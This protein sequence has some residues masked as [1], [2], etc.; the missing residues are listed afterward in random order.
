MK[1]LLAEYTAANDPALAPEGVAMLS[2][3][4]RSFERSGYEVISPAKGDFAREIAR[5]APSCDYGLVIA[6]DPLLAKFT[7]LIEQHTDN[8]G[9]GS[10]SASICANKQKSARILRSHGIPVPDEPGS[11]RRVVKPVSGCGSAGV[12]LTDKP[13]GAGEFSQQFIDG[14]HLSVSLVCN[15]IVGEACLNFSGEPPV[16]LALNR[17][18]I[19]TDKN[20]SFHYLG[21][22]TPVDHPR[23]QEVAECAI[24]AAMTLGCQGYCGIDIVLADRPYIVDVNPRITTSIVG[25][26]ACMQEEIA[27]IIVDAAHGHAPADLHFTGRVRFDKDGKVTRQ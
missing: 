24:R 2:V 9:C 3:M 19:T 13:A 12:R 16:V 4:Q 20:G 22:E 18:E 8:I 11:G 17:Q 27:R 6:P 15:R 25:I 21:G 5:L 26:A 1:V 23:R 10:T 14:E 7:M